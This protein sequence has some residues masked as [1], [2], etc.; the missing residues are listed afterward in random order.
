MD[1]VVGV[2]GVVKECGCGVGGLLGSAARKSDGPWKRGAKEENPCLVRDG[3]WLWGKNGRAWWRTGG[4]LVVVRCGA[5]PAYI[6]H[7]V[8]LTTGGCGVDRPPPRTNDHPP[9]SGP[10]ILSVAGRPKRPDSSYAVRGPGTIAALSAGW[11]IR[12]CRGRSMYNTITHMGL[13]SWPPRDLPGHSYTPRR[14]CDMST[15]WSCAY[16][17]CKRLDTVKARASD[18]VLPAEGRLMC[19][20]ER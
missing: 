2:G 12:R 5:S 8:R 4:G 9:R 3:N 18:V 20:R 14:Q 10:W 11:A 19:V 1:G 16:P 17:P 13:T 15:G 7:P 6:G